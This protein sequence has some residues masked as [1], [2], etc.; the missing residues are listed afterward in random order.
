VNFTKTPSDLIVETVTNW[1]GVSAEP[2][3]RGSLS[4]RFESKREL[5]HLHGNRSAH[6]TFPKELGDRL[7]REGWVTD[8]PLGEKYRGL[9]ARRI[10]SD[11]DIEEVIALIR[12]NYDREVERDQG[13]TASRW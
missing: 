12:L 7:K 1:P 6:F 3:R 5:A 13:K 8:H 9:A 2:G 4:L 11:E 10:E